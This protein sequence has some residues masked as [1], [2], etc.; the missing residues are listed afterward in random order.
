MEEH[1]PLIIGLT[2]TPSMLLKRISPQRDQ[3]KLNRAAE[4]GEWSVRDTVGHLRDNESRTY[5]KLFMLV[6]MEYPD[7]RQADL[8]NRI[9]HDPDDSAFSVLSQFRRLRQSTL[10]LLRELPRDAWKRSGRDVDGSTIDV[11]SLAEDLLDHD[12]E[13]LEQIDATLAARGALPRTVRPV[14]MA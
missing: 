7:L 4:R 1:D 13:H 3:A 5:T 2:H 14:V 8:T 9:D 12:R 6:T 11:R 10:S